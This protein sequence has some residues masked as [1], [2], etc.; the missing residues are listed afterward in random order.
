MKRFVAAAL[1]SFYVLALILDR[2]AGVIYGVLALCG[3]LMIAYGRTESGTTFW[4]ATRLYWPL[5]LAMAAPLIAVLAHQISTGHFASRSGDSPS[6]LALY[7]LI[8][9]AVSLV[10][11]KYL[12]QVQWAFVVGAFLSAIKMYVLTD[13]GKDRYGTDFIPIIIFAEM[14]LLLGIFA[15]FSIAW[16]QRYAILAMLLKLA[17]AGA[18][19]YAA[20]ISRSRGPWLTILVFGLIVFAAAK[21]LRRID[22][23]LISFMAGAVL[24]AAVAS[25]FQPGS[26]VRERITVAQSNIQEYVDGKNV[27]TSLGI[28]F[29]LWRGS[30]IL[31]KENPV[32]GV[33]V[34][35]YQS[36]LQDLARRQIISPTAATFPH[37]HNDI[38]FMMAKLGLFGLAAIL[39]VYFVPLYYFARDFRNSDKEI[40]SVAAMGIAQ[41]L[42]I[43]T[44]GLTDV[45]FLWWEIFP[46]YSIS[47]ALFLAYIVRRKTCLS[48]RNEHCQNGK[49]STGKSSDKRET[50]RA[51]S[52]NL[53][54][55][56]LAAN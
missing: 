39:M 45:V 11:L 42:G 26:I 18:V 24:A 22:K 6:R 41:S 15:A 40:R 10:P 56:C 52:D 36:A 55:S 33:G 5:N 9:W 21:S 20:Y 54:S 13:E 49:G 3:L 43:M 23:L 37:S 4:Q 47:V 53:F 16:N 27:D 7:P 48:D 25:Y 35:N 14:G 38:L 30:W 12:R 29:Q 2:A 31:F 1:I 17:A 44:L 46:F 34:E 32:F 50:E 28:R 19:M 8:F 51:S